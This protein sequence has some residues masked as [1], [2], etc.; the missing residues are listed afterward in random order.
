MKKKLTLVYPHC[1]DA[2]RTERLNGILQDILDGYNCTIMRYAEDFAP[3]Q[4]GIVLF[5]VPL[6]I[7]GD[8]KSV[9]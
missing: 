5:A 8:R 2:K 9:V 7:S 3:I 6:G 4:G 1:E